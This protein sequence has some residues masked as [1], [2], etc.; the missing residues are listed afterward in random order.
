MSDA[1]RHG[2]AGGVARQPAYPRL[3]AAIVT[4]EVQTVLAWAPEGLHR[5][6][7]EIEDLL[8]LIER[9][10]VSVETSGGAMGRRA[11]VGSDTP[12]CTAPAALRDAGLTSPGSALPT[13]LSGIRVPCG[14]P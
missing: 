2:L 9:H 8:E 11:A 12:A 10:G 7:R 4:G 3:T 1:S 6:P 5:S 14:G 13:T